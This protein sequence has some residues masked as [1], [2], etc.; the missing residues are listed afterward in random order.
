M[1]NIVI[2]RTGLDTEST[3]YYLV[4]EAQGLNKDQLHTS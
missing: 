2:Q 1:I 4:Q 3:F